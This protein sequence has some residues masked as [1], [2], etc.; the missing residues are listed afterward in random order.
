MS[1]ATRNCVAALFLVLDTSHAISQD[2]STTMACLNAYTSTNMEA[3]AY[4]DQAWR[5][6]DDLIKCSL[7]RNA[8]QLYTRLAELL[9]QCGMTPPAIGVDG[10]ARQQLQFAT[11]ACN[12]AREGMR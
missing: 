7:H 5:E 3:Q 12:R 2:Y 8:Q 11:E 10:L 9:R 4:A 6:S 1:I